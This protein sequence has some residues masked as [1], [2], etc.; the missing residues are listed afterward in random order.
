MATSPPPITPFSGLAPQR[1]DKSTFGDRFDAF[2][3]WFIAA[4]ANLP[5]LA[6][7][8]YSNALEAF[9]SAGTATAAAAAALATVNAS[10]WVSGMTSALNVTVISPLNFQTYRRRVAG[11]G[12]VDPANDQVNWSVLAGNDSNGAFIPTPIGALDIDLSQSNYFTKTVAANS[13]FTFSNVPA[14]GC[15]FTLEITHTAGSI[16]FPASVKMIGNISPALVTGKTH[17]FMFVTSNGGARWRATS[18]ANFD[19]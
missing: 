3:T 7:N 4:V 17:L 12:T 19:T 6:L 2:I 9:Q 14:G 10:P 13:T 1:K 11:A 5:A 15:S 16:A 18:L 8:V